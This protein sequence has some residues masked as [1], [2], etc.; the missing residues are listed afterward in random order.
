MQLMLFL[1]KAYVLRLYASRCLRQYVNKVILKKI[2]FYYRM[3]IFN[4]PNTMPQ[5][6]LKDNL[7][8]MNYLNMLLTYFVYFNYITSNIS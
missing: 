2:I 5:K 8:I 4:I 1:S 3:L 6:N 7:N